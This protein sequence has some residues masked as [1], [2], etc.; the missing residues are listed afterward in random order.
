MKSDDDFLL[1]LERMLL[2]VVKGCNTIDMP[3]A[4]RAA[5]VRRVRE[6]LLTAVDVRGRGRPAD[7]AKEVAGDPS[8]EAFVVDS[9]RQ[10]LDSLAIDTKVEKENANLRRTVA[11]LTEEVERLKAQR[12]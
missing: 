1:I 8:Q 10:S 7:I 11:T 2:R 12:R 5:L 6:R 3:W 9:L 4:K